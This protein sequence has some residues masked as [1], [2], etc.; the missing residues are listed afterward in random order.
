MSWQQIAMIIWISWIVLLGLFEHGKPRKG[1][2]N[3]FVSLFSAALLTVILYT[4][5]F[6]R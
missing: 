3:F 1:E 2:G 5:G 6:W 4:G